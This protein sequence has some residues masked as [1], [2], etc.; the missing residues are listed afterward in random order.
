MVVILSVIL[1]MLREN[2]G[3]TQQ[4]VADALNIDRSTYTYYEIGK[5]MPD[6]NMI[7]KLARIFSVPYSDLLAE[8]ARYLDANF[9]D[10]DTSSLDFTY[11]DS[12]LTNH[13]YEL[14]KEEKKL[15]ASFRALPGNSKEKIMAYVCSEIKKTSKKHG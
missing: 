12:R 13:T 15:I 8:E 9:S 2:N 6:I 10:V 1:K 4:Q 7:I 11:R 5:T 14:S 3:Y